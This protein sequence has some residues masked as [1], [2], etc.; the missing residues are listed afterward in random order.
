V[1]DGD[2]ILVPGWL[3]IHESPTTDDQKKI[4]ISFTIPGDWSS[5]L[6][7]STTLGVDLFN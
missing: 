5:S 2:L 1:E 7:L 4:T 3:A 6:Q